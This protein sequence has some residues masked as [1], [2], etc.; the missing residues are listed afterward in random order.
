MPH[1]QNIYSVL[2]LLEKKKGV[3]NLYVV[4]STTL[5]AQV[6]SSKKEQQ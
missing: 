5:M 2:D 1:P 6:N 4:R 3:T